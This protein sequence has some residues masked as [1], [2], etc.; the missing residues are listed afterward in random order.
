MYHKSKTMRYLQLS[1]IALFLATF[2]ML[3]FT[4]CSKDDDDDDDNQQQQQNQD[5]VM[6]FSPSET[7]QDDLQT[8]LITM[9]NGTVIE[10][11]AGTYNFDSS[12][13][14]KDKNNITIR[15]A[16]QDETILD[17]SGQQ[18]G[19]EGILGE[20]LDMFL[21]HDLT[22]R[23]AIGDNIKI[24][25]SDGITFMDMASV[26]T[27]PADET[28]GAY[29][30]YPVTSTHVLIDNVYIRGASDAG[31]Y[32]GQSDK[33]IVR[34]SL[35]EENVAGI[36]VENCTDAEVVGNTCRNNTGGILVFSLPGLP[37]I[38]NGLRTRVYD[39]KLHNNN[40]RNFAPPGNMVEA[41]PP[42]CGI[43]CLANSS[44]EVF[45]N[46]IH[47]NAVMGVGIVSFTTLVALAG[48]NLNDE[49]YKPYCK[50]IYIH[51][52]DFRK[53][54]P[55]QED[56]NQIGGI[57]TGA[58]G[59]PNPEDMPH[60]IWDSQVDPDLAPGEKQFCIQED[61]DVTF[62]ASDI[63]NFFQNKNDDITPFLC[64]GTVLAPVTVNAP[65]PE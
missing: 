42:G 62:G 37:V 12:I 63:T 52:N 39:N 34:N 64:E 50:D 17:F 49:D 36:E 38:K 1:L 51:D 29:A 41:V 5:G 4:G 54:V 27:G 40:H 28:N 46:E 15:G 11:A 30:L 58:Y 6:Q 55:Y 24:Q 43:M 57:L 19:A 53:D 48:E 47:D 8:A 13:S 22:V 23:D 35:C 21:M 31:I 65:L 60:I 2:S 20:N 56:M 61:P 26:Y 10:L 32:V 33:V 59:Y 25:D 7:F 9:E 16:G 14:I 44:I 3:T 45:N 18:A